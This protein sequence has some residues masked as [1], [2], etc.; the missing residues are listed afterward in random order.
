[1]SGDRE[2]DSSHFYRHLLMSQSGTQ[3]RVL[4]FHPFSTKTALEIV[5]EL[6]QIMPQARQTP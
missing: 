3:T 1:M 5:S 6:A 2:C 4:N